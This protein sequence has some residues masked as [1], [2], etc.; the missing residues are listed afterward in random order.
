[1]R[2]ETSTSFQMNNAL[3]IPTDSS[4]GLPIGRMIRRYVSHTD[5][6]SMVAAS[7]MLRG[8]RR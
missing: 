7:V 1:M 5:A 6:P 2:S 4:A 8:M 3:R